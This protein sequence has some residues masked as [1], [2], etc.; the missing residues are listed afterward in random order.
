MQTHA[1]YYYGQDIVCA[2]KRK[3]V[4]N[5]S[6]R[7][8]FREKRVCSSAEVMKMYNDEEAG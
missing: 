3:L 8:G 1:G 6:G 4:G 2:G 5:C 7:W